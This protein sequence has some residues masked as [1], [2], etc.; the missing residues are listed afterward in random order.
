MAFSGFAP[1]AGSKTPQ[2]PHMNGAEAYLM[3]AMT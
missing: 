1:E 3:R 2:M